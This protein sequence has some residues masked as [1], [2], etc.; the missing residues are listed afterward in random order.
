MYFGAPVRQ[1]TIGNRLT[2][3]RQRFSGPWSPNPWTNL[4]FVGPPTARRGDSGCIQAEATLDSTT[5]LPED[6]ERRRQ[7]KA[8]ISAWEDE[9]GSLTRRVIPHRRNSSL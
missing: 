4:L 1:I 6:C 7:Q 8:A 9:G 5:T 2:Q 3:R